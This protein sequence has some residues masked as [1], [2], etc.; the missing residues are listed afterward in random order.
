[1][2]PSPHQYSITI[3]PKKILFTWAPPTL[4]A[5][6]ASTSVPSTPGIDP[7]SLTWSIVGATLGATIDSSSGVV[8]AGTNTG[9]ITV[10]AEEVGGICFEEPLEFVDCEKCQ[11]SSVENGSVDVKLD[12]GWSLVHDTAGFLQIHED[13]P[14][15]D[16]ATPHKLRYNFLRPNVETITNSQ[17]LRQL[18]APTVLANVVTNT[19]QKYTVELYNPTNVLT[20]G[21]DG[22]YGLTNTP[23]RQ[24]VIENPSGD[25]NKLRVTETYDG[26]SWIFEYAWLTNGWQ[27]DSGGGLR[28]ET[29]ITELSE[30]NTLKT[31]NTTVQEPGNLPYIVKQRSIG[32]RPTGNG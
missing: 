28:R 2:V 19:A 12:L 5:D 20:K 10:R 3:R 31:V 26:D 29:K 17:G 7:S 27:L 4:P 14:T 24:F 18:R 25:T 32:S 15:I 9:T 8:V 6:G 11:C 21:V 13:Y 1:M 23:Y 22:Y 30:T 16:L